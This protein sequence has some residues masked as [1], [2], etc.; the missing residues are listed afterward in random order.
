MQYAI[1]AIYMKQ[2]RTQEKWAFKKLLIFFVDFGTTFGLQFKRFAR[3]LA[4]ISILPRTL[5]YLRL[6]IIL[7][8]L[9]LMRYRSSY[10]KITTSTNWHWYWSSLWFLIWIAFMF[11]AVK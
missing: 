6:L 10:N 7:K 1:L 5:F 11:S 2:I 4:F 9:Y 8:L 3:P